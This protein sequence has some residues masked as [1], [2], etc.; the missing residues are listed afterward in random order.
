MTPRRIISAVLL[1][2][3]VCAAI[4]SPSAAAVPPAKTGWWWATGALPLSADV[5]SGDLLVAGVTLPSR[6]ALP[7]PIPDPT[8]PIS[9]PPSRGAGGVAPPGVS[10]MAAISFDIPPGERLLRVVLH[11]RASTFPATPLTSGA[12]ACPADA[13][14]QPAAGGSANAIPRFDCTRSSL[15]LLDSTNNTLTFANIADLADGSKLTLVILPVGPT[16]MV[17]S[18]PQ[19]DALQF[20]TSSFPNPVPI[21]GGQV[22]PVVA[23]PDGPSVTEGR[24]RQPTGVGGSVPVTTTDHSEPRVPTS[25]VRP[26]PPA[27]VRAI[28]ERRWLALIALIGGLGWYGFVAPGSPFAA[29]I[30]RRRT[31]TPEPA[32]TGIGRFRRERAGSAPAL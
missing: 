17:V 10:A 32:L 6:P 27:L 8:L 23:P 14:F 4:G 21:G 15:A 30:E 12:M 19:D 24:P 28:D 7:L 13:G 31:A 16:R 9:V 20:V 26:N 22:D 11:V 1:A 5:G 29:V 2:I 18:G 25:D 3:A